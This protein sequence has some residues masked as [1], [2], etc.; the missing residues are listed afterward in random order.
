MSENKTSTENDTPAIDRQLSTTLI[1]FISM[2]AGL[3]LLAFGGLSL[4][5]TIQ[6]TDLIENAPIHLDQNIVAVLM[7]LSGIIL[8]IAGFGVWRTL[9][10][11]FYLYLL[12]FIVAI[13]FMLAL[14][15]TNILTKIGIVIVSSIL[16]A[17]LGE[18]EYYK[19]RKSKE[20]VNVAFLVDFVVYGSMS[21]GIV[22]ILLGFASLIDKFV[23]ETGFFENL[24]TEAT[25]GNEVLSDPMIVGIIAI[26]A[27]IIFVVSGYGLSKESSW[28]W[29]IFVV[30][31]LVVITVIFLM[32]PL[33]L[34]FILP[35][36]ALL[37]IALN[38]GALIANYE[39]FTN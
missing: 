13:I 27:G 4:A 24:F 3:G 39:Y 16:G 21:S 31:F 2:L 35:S 9:S 14:F 11:A 6:I 36:A 37:L 23:L 22:G 8:L 17:L 29:Y 1:G 30:G 38:L 5:N 10:W 25:G 19:G 18:S 34:E 15:S 26:L 20:D 32:S 12:G 33:E 7:A 28:A